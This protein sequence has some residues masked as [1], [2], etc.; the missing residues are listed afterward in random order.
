MYVL[1]KKI[2]QSNVEFCESYTYVIN[3]PIDLTGALIAAVLYIIGVYIRFS[4][5]YCRRERDFFAFSP[6]YETWPIFRR[7]RNDVL[8]S[9]RLCRRHRCRHSH[10]QQ[11]LRG[12]NMA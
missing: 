5:C 9:P 3:G 8:T 10:Q 11:N 2:M 6:F 4:A 12:D 1:C 7:Q